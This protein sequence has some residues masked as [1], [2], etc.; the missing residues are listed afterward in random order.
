MFT[1]PVE[2]VYAPRGFTYV[3]CYTVYGCFFDFMYIYN[4]I[5]V[6]IWKGV[7]CTTLY[8]T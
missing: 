1:L 4:C 6:P 5:H 2:H 7:M 3:L 8:M